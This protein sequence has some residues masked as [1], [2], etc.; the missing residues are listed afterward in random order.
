M[1]VNIARASHINEQAL[2][3]APKNGGAICTLTAG[4]TAALCKPLTGGR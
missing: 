1:L 4:P 2:L 3:D